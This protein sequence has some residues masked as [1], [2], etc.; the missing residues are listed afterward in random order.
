MQP[1]HSVVA[2]VETSIASGEESRRVETLRRLTTLFLEQAPALGEEHVTVFDEVI[3]RLAHEIEFRAR[4]ELA[5]RLA[6][7]AN[8]P[9]RTV[10][11]LAFDENIQIA[12][13]VIERS[14]RL[15]ESDLV[16]LAR[17]R[18]QSHLLALSGRRHLPESVTDVLV[19][20]GDENVV[21]R[22]AGNETAR[23]STHGFDTLVQRAA[24]DGALQAILGERKDLPAAHA[25]ALIEA[26]KQQAR[27]DMAQSLG[28][29]PDVADLL[30]D[31][32][33][34]SA[35]AVAEGGLEPIDFTGAAQRVDALESI[36]PLGEEVVNRL[37]REEK[38][39]DALV[40]LSRISGL[41]AD[42]VGTAYS[43]ASYDPLLFIVRGVKFGWPT[44]KL[45]LRAKTGKAP[46]QAL[47]QQAFASFEALTIPTAQ[48][49]MRFVATKSKLGG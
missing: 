40:V 19:E 34:A 15:A 13:P 35:R 32:L 28:D 44:F 10:R 22:V 7:V 17:E 26:A 16:D 25:A 31:A 48:R 23:F 29:R 20:R 8:A 30:G 36:G 43:A 41:P 37:L 27:R 12:R 4:V 5:E 33:D 1:F 39:P 9:R 14:A 47:L 42:A 3:S 21:R 49:V 46:P 6:D 18:G 2:E 38:V 11:D 45:L 24:D